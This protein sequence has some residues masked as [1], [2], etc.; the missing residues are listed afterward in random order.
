MVSHHFTVADGRLRTMSVPFR[1]VWPAELDLMARL[2]G[3][4]HRFRDR[5]RTPFTG[6]SRQHVSVWGRA[7]PSGEIPGDQARD[8]WVAQ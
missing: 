1:S 6:E 3:L 4:R 5:H 2:A 8:E 7:T